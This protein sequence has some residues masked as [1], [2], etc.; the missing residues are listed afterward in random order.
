MK[1]IILSLFAMF[2][3]G[4]EPYVP[5]VPAVPP[6]TV[7][8]G[9]TMLT[10]HLVTRV[11]TH[12][13]YW[14]FSND[15]GVPHAANCNWDITGTVTATFYPYGSVVIG[16]WRNAPGTVVGNTITLI[17][18]GAPMWITLMLAPSGNG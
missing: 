3:L 4:C 13:G 15:P 2:T 11:G 1:L 18:N 10:S 6:G 17:G 14:L 8:P 5:P 12:Y 16:E 7:P 9:G